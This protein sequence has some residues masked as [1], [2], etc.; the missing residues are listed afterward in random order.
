MT[1]KPKTFAVNGKL[2][3]AKA[4][5]WAE[6][7]EVQFRPGYAAVIARFLK[8]GSR[9]LD[10]GCGS[11]V[12]AQMAAAQGVKVSGIDAAQSLFAIARER[13]SAGDFRV[14]DMEELPFGDAAFD[15][16]TGFNAFQY[17][18][19]PVKAL[20]EAGRVVKPDGHVVIVTWGPPDN[21]PAASL[22][23]ALRPLLPP[24][25]PGARQSGR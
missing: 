23:A 11:G 10:V 12:A 14:A 19:N 4:R 13:T 16:V 5:D 1:D 15:L 3:G 25:P 22:L 24:P 6:L 8:P 2:W 9:F 20:A 21:M 17:A 18:G 7:Q